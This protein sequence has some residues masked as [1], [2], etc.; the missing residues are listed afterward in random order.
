MS[1]KRRVIP[2]WVTALV[3]VGVAVA[4]PLEAKKK[5]VDPS[6]FLG[7][8][9]EL[10]PH[11]DRKDLLVYRLRERVLAD[12]DAFI[13]E[14]P[15]VYFA[16]NAQG[17]GVDPADLTM[18]AGDLREKLAEAITEAEGYSLVEEAGPGV[19]RIRVAIT[20]VVP[21]DPKK[22]VGVKAA[23][24]AVGIGLLVPRVDLGRAAIEAE[25]TDSESGERLVAVA[26]TREARRF[27]GVIKGSKEWGDVRAAFKKWAKQFRQR[28]DE[29][30]AE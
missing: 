20:E 2:A 3:V 29:V 27:G 7:D 23:G 8:Y 1:R 28:L 5:D 21:V 17:V 14:P 26:A 16:P 15:L 25:I 30:R 13:L 24:M 9:S 18:L 22:N 4:P 6:G 12:Y 10:S 19:A 11:P